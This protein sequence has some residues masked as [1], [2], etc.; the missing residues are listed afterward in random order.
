MKNPR[1]LKRQANLYAGKAVRESNDGK[2]REERLQAERR[3]ILSGGRLNEFT[4]DDEILRR[5]NMKI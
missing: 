4:F 3:I 1:R 5:K 2:R